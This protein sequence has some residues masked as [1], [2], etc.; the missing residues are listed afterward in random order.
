MSK[1][2]NISGVISGVTFT[3][4]KYKKTN[5]VNDG[6]H[7]QVEAINDGKD[8]KLDRIINKFKSG[9]K[10]TS[11]E[12]AY[13]AEKAP[14]IY[15]KV[16]RVM[17]QREV[18]EQRLENVRTKEEAA[19]IVM[20]EMQSVSSGGDDEFV[21]TAMLNHIM[22][23]YNKHLASAGSGGKTEESPAMMNEEA[24]ALYNLNKQS[25]PEDFFNHR[26]QYLLKNRK[27]KPDSLSLF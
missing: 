21:K 15:S 18:I 24:L 14:D 17:K 2:F 3:S 22:D 26:N 20:E 16:I 7:S 27:D 19:K 8:H 4:G 9:K 1:S 13:L 10:L 25:D 6:R 12:L 11:G 23:A 5:A